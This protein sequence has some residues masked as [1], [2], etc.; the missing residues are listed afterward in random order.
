MI[1]ACPRCGSRYR[2][3]REQIRPEGVRV[4]CQRC[5]AAFRVRAPSRAVERRS[6][7]A[8]A[9]AVTPAD[10]ARLVVLAHPDPERA[11]AIAAALGEAGLEVVIAHD[12]VEAIL[13]IQRV[14]PRA[15]ILEASLPRM[16]GFQIC[17]LMKRNESLRGIGVLLVGSVHRPERYRRPPGE[18]YGADGYLEGPDVAQAALEHLGRMGLPVVRSVPR[19]ATRGAVSAPAA[20]PARPAA[21]PDAAEALRRPLEPSPAPSP[22]PRGEAVAKAERLARIIVSDIVLYNEEK[23][24]AALQSG[25]VIEALEAELEEGR[26][27]FRE[28]VEA[29]VRELRDFLSD[30]LL[31][32]ARTRGMK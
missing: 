31:R 26:A 15:V 20:E 9:G 22:E 30:E 18:L 25:N 23:F 8:A 13:T 2:I 11:K 3:A 19:Q 10:R 5:Q 12:G 6:S 21:T 28:R 24:R 14:L 17:E 1:A 7:A 32:V 29:P 27:L 16:Y 4:R